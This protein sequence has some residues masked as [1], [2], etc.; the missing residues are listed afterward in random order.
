MVDAREK[1]PGPPPALSALIKDIPGDSQ[2]WSAYSGGPIQLPFQATGNLSNINTIV[3]SIQGGSLYLDLRTGLSGLAT[4]TART[5][6]GAQDLEG[7][8]K[9]LVGLGRLSTPSNPPDLQRVWDGIRITQ[10][11]SS[12]KLHIDEPEDLVE[13]FVELTLGRL[14]AAK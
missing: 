12:V 5:E 14:P 13:K 11:E 2:V 9:A 4:G 1:P 3:Q 7:G 10:Q 8:L 6:A